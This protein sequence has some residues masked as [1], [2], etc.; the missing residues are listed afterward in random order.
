MTK[1]TKAMRIVPT[2][3]VPRRGGAG[4]GA[5]SWLIALL[6]LLPLAT[7]GC[8]S[9]PWKKKDNDFG[10]TGPSDSLVLGGGGP[11]KYRGVLDST[12]QA[13]VDTA[14]RLFLNKEYAPAEDIFH[15]VLKEK[16]LP[17]NVA[18]EL[19]F[20]EG[21]CQFLQ[22]HYRDAM[23]TFRKH[24]KNYRNGPHAQQSIARLFQIADYWLEGTRA[25][26]EAKADGKKNWFVMPASMSIHFSKD[27]PTTDIEGHAL[28]ALEEV[29]FNDIGGP[30]GEQ[31]CFYIATV[32]FFREKYR[33]ADYYFSQLFEHYP[34][35][36]L[37]PK[38]MKQSIICKQICTGG[39]CYDCRSVEE[40]RK[41]LDVAP[42]AY[43]SL[44]NKE[45]DW[46][47]RQLV[48]VNLQQADRDFNIAEFYRRT[49]HPGP[50]YFYYELVRRCYPNTEYA[51]KAQTRMGELRSRV[52]AEQAA[53]RT[54]TPTPP[55]VPGLPL[56]LPAGATPPP[57]GEPR[58]LP[59][60]LSAPPG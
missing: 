44:A 23:P 31:A 34:N 13:E 37:A 50:A 28:Q 27:K 12:L 43:P 51:E 21:E 17:V 33:D 22:K 4:T 49:G 16:N 41:L 11:E 8:M 60:E 54:A 2:R 57:G 9:L 3:I 39:T 14:H 55:V 7:S 42:A 36:K 25:E 6:A 24:L 56:R 26:M 58:P 40:T 19:L 52:D 1:A 29:R 18:E 47:E 48:A 15:R 5:R 10:L 35:S 53:D 45:Q 20:Y 59:S 30:H 46:L 38:A 32:K